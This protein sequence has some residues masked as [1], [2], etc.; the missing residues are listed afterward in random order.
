MRFWHIFG[1]VDL[2]MEKN[3]FAAPDVLPKPY[4]PLITRHARRSD[5]PKS[6]DNVFIAYE[7]VPTQKK[8]AKTGDRAT[9]HGIRRSGVPAGPKIARRK[10]IFLPIWR[11]TK[12]KPYAR[13]PLDEAVILSPQT[14]S[15]DHLTRNHPLLQNGA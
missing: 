15:G 1:Q 5:A 14:L 6:M 8:W 11:G 7:H 4:H 10:Y 9:V 2:S 12:Q 3:T 13:N